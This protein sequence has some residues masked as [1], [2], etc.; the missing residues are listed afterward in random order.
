MQ[1]QHEERRQTVTLS[2][3]ELEHIT[4]RVSQEVAEK[5]ADIAVAK[6]MQL[7]YAEI[8]KRTIKNILLFIGLATSALA[9]WLKDKGVF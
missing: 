8:G 3:E 4:S 7:L 6:H 5:A 9:I 2:L 1:E